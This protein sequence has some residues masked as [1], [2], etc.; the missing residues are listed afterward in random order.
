MYNNM[1]NNVYNN[2]YSFSKIRFYNKLIIM[3][4]Y[5]VISWK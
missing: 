3:N 5:N 2:M 4:I 1:Y